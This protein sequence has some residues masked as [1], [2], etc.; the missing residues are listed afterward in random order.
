MVAAPRPAIVALIVAVLAAGAIFR[1]VT[2]GA[3]AGSIGVPELP[4]PPSVTGGLLVVV[5]VEG[6]D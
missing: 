3:P 6:G 4:E 1:L 5:V 2:S